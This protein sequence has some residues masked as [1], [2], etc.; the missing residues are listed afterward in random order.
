MIEYYSHDIMHIVFMPI[1]L[2]LE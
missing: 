1:L 2:I